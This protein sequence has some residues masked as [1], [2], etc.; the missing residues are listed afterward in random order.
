MYTYA[1]KLYYYARRNN[2]CCMF[3]SKIQFKEILNVVKIYT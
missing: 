1:G 3:V 2:K